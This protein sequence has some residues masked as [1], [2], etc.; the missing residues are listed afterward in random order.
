MVQH[1]RNDGS[2]VFTG[3]GAILHT[4]DV[5]NQDL[6]P[7]LIADGNGGF[8]ISYLKGG[9]GTMDLY[10][11]CYKDN[12]GTLKNYGGG[13]V[14]QNGFTVWHT[15]YCGNYTTVEYFQTYVIDYKIYPDLQKGC[16]VVMTFSQNGGIPN[17]NDR[18]QV[19]FNWLWRVKKDAATKNAVFLKDNVA[20]FYNLNVENGNLM[21]KDDVNNIVY[22]YPTNKLLSNGMMPLSDWGVWCRTC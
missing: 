15:G 3:A 11:Y 2:T 6:A 5:A 22:N 12:N 21:C 18:L 1:I 8:F 20:L 9:Y 7:Q 14:N 17:T 19:A 16:N 13:L 4:S 10:V